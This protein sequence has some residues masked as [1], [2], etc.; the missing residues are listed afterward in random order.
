MVNMASNDKV[1]EDVLSILNSRSQDIFRKIVERYLDNR[2]TPDATDD[3]VN[4]AFS[5]SKTNRKLLRNNEIFS[6]FFSIGALL[7]KAFKL[8]NA[9]QRHTQQRHP[10]KMLIPRASEGSDHGVVS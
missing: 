10:H 3:E 1:P 5:K 2:G 9:V 8:K 6:C 7:E 4:I